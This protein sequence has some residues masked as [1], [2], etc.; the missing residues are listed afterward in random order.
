MIKKSCCI[1]GHSF[2]AK[3]AN[4]YC[5]SPECSKERRRQYQSRYRRGSEYWAKYYPQLHA[6]VRIIKYCK[7]C[8][9]ELPH[10]KQTYCLDCLLK[11]YLNDNK[12]EALHIL[13]SRGYDKAMIKE[14]LKQRGWI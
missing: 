7:I 1:C 2:Q 6:K 14:E 10:G 11:M 13:G 5:C 4:V 3:S 12:H 8:S 9:H